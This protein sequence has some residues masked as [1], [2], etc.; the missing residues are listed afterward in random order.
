MLKAIAD[1]NA[2]RYVGG[3]AKVIPGPGY[4][5]EFQFGHC[6]PMRQR[7]LAADDNIRLNSQRLERIDRVFA[8]IPF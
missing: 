4:L 5:K 1:G 3:R 8:R 6:R 7:Y 2:A